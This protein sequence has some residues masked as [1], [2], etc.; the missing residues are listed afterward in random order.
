MN[1][2][3]YKKSG[4]VIANIARQM[5]LMEPGGRLP[6]IQEFTEMFDSSRGVVQNAL[7]VLQK[8]GGIVLENR[9]K[10]G[11]F[12]VA[13]DPGRLF[14]LANI[15]SITGS[16]PTPLN[17]YIGGLAT[18]ICQAMSSCPAPFAFAFMQGSEQRA[19]ALVRS[20]YDFVVVTAASAKQHVREHPELEIVM[21]LDGC[22]YSPQ[23]VLC[24]YSD[25]PD[26]IGEGC[27]VGVDSTS[28]D[29]YTITRRL[30]AGKKVNFRPIPYMGLRSALMAREIDCIVYRDFSALLSEGEFRVLPIGDEKQDDYL[31]PAVVSNRN[32]FGMAAIVKRYLDPR[33]VAAS[34]KDVLEYRAE[35]RF[36]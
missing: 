12:L 31:L 21:T 22:S 10:M 25:A 15:S 13:N 5:I 3:Y 16:M 33:V 11:S 28:T 32:N 36:F 17:R 14:G 23:F 19:G 4:L 6:T 1:T 8:E 18:G 20:L 2:S 24:T 27:V 35:P 30:C 29:H 34:Q 7:M 26:G 9:G